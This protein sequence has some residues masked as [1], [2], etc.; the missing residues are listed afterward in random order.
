MAGAPTQYKLVLT[1]QC[2]LERPAPSRIRQ[3]KPTTENYRQRVTGQEQLNTA[4]VIL[5]VTPAS[6]SL[7]RRRKI[8]PT[9]RPECRTGITAILPNC[10]RATAVR[11][12]WAERKWGAHASAKEF[13]G[14]HEIRGRGRRGDDPAVCRFTE[15]SQDK[16]EQ[17]KICAL[18]L[19]RPTRQYR[20][21]PRRI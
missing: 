14:W 4:A 8:L 11:Y 9:P 12:H 15:R 19:S 20:A 2:D 13:S 5:L 6:H 18:P 7:G 3:S 16:S 10:S 1:Y 21:G 17:P